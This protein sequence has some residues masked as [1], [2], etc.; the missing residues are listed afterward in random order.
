MVQKN[1]PSVTVM[2]GCLNECRL[3]GQSEEYML[4]LRGEYIL[5]GCKIKD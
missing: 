1:V 2:G 4:V 5:V 3:S